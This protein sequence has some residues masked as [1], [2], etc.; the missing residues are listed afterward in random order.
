MF[1]SESND[2]ADQA[3][4]VK[5]VHYAETGAKFQEAAC[6]G[7]GQRFSREGSGIQ[8]KTQASGL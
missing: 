4:H 2:I 7:G 5:Q 8:L 1:N 6:A 3:L